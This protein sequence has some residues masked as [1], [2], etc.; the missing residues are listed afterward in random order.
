[1]VTVFGRKEAE[2]LVAEARSEGGS[3]PDAAALLFPTPAPGSG[4]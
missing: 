1:L 4:S 3:E 2:R